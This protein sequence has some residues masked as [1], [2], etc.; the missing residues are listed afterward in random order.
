M[1]GAGKGVKGGIVGSE[2]STLAV[3]VLVH[4]NR[5]PVQLVGSVT[6]KPKAMSACGSW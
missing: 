2:Y 4:Q 1:V 3:A 5:I 6:L